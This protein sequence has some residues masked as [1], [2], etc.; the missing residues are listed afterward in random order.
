MV[1]GLEIG[2][3]TSY[4]VLSVAGNEEYRIYGDEATT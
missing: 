2:W 3:M 1:V 4:F